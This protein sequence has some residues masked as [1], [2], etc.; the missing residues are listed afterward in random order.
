MDM[1]RLESLP[2]M[3][4][5]LDGNTYALW[6]DR[7]Q[8]YLLAIGVDVWLLVKNGYTIPKTRPK[9]STTKKLHRDNAMPISAIMGGLSD[10]DKNKLG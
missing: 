2:S 3:F 10:Y 8:T 6:S 5:I 1:D 4:L 7:N 9:G